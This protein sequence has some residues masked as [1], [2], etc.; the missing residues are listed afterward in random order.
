MKKINDKSILIIEIFFMSLG[1]FFIISSLFIPK[2][3]SWLT[4]NYQFEAPHL[5]ILIIGLAGVGFAWYHNIRTTN[6]KRQDH[7]KQISSITQSFVNIGITTGNIL[8]GY[9][10]GILVTYVISIS[11][12]ETQRIV[13]GIGIM[14][15]YTSLLGIFAK[16]DKQ[17]FLIMVLITLMIAWLLSIVSGLLD[18]AINN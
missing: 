13:F 15:I 12:T 6:F 14:M 7:P 11:I 1:T 8:L 16:K 10:L 4:I 18:N 3:F 2:L 5:V 17:K 9:L